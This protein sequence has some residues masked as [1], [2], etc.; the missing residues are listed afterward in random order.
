M[1]GGNP[2]V[3]MGKEIGIEIGNEQKRR[4]GKWKVKS[5]KSSAGTGRKRG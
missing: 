3:M 5:G 4:E 2:S 1:R